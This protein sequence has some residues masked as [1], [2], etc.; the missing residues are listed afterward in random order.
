MQ[1]IQK[2][3]KNMEKE[4]RGAEH[5]ISYAIEEKASHGDIDIINGYIRM[6]QCELDNADTL[7]SIVLKV[8]EKDRS[9]HGEP[10]EVMKRIWAYEH[11]QYVDWA[12]EIKL[13][14]DLAKK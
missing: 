6:A 11:E 12:S 1:K 14:L 3:I 7:H 9:D 2:L 5:Y 13:K 10:P 4:L 8:I